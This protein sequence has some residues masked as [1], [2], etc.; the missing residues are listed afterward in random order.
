MSGVPVS[1]CAVCGW[2]GFPRRFWCPRCGGDDVATELVE[3]GVVAERTTLRRAAGRPSTPPVPI[4]T[5]RLAGGGAAIARLDAAE[6]GRVAL[7]LMGGAPVARPAD[8]R[9]A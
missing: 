7:T 8:A 9:E 3:A 2:R 1:V 5:V 6:D 4:A